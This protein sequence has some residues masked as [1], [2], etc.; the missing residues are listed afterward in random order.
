MGQLLVLKDIGMNPHEINRACSHK[1]D[2]YKG[3][4]LTFGNGKM[5]EWFKAHAWNAC[6]RESVT[7]VRIPLF[8]PFP[9]KSILRAAVC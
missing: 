1:T 7:R 4:P 9:Q 8:P 5:A 3:A 6:L 2:S